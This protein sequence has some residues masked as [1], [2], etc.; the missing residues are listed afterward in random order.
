MVLNG[1]IFKKGDRKELKNYRPVSLLSVPGMVLERCLGIQMEDY[2]EEK[3]ILQ[4]FQYGFRRNR[5][6]ISELHTLFHRLLKA[7]EQ[8]KDISL[9][10]FDLSAAFDTVDHR[11]L[12]AKLQV[13]GFDSC[14]M[15]MIQSYLAD[16]T[17]KVTVSGL[18]S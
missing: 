14:A 2:L 3:N 1:P 12:L 10:L 16:R 9:L 8:G 6:C 15:N 13:Y 11:I 7:K 5:S 17:Q 4:D 18:L